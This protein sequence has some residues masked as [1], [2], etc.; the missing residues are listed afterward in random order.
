MMKKILLFLN[1]LI[2]LLSCSYSSKKANS[3]SSHG[4]PLLTLVENH[5]GYHVAYTDDGHFVVYGEDSTGSV[6]AYYTKFAEADKNYT[7]NR[8]KE[9]M[10]RVEIDSSL[11]TLKSLVTIY[12]GAFFELS[13]LPGY[14]VIYFDEQMKSDSILS[15]EIPTDAGHSDDVAEFVAI[16]QIL[17]QLNVAY[18]LAIIVNGN[19]ASGWEDIV[20]LLAPSQ[21][22]LTYSIAS[23]DSVY[24]PIAMERMLRISSATE[25]FLQYAELLRNIRCARP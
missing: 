4:K 9:K 11:V 6:I 25:R 5:N 8:Y 22:L 18:Q 10:V 20:S 16:K 19:K 3:V 13:P 2:L 14:K 1:A 23:S 12:G 24:N 15:V 17:L 21:N 7:D